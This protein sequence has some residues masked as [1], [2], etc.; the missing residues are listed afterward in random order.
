MTHDERKSHIVNILRDVAKNGAING[1]EY[2]E[3]MADRI[4]SDYIAKA[5]IT[6]P[7]VNDIEMPVITSNE[8]ET[9]KNRQK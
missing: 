6:P 2:L 9:G 5:V 3:A 7:V 1:K 8:R 4:M